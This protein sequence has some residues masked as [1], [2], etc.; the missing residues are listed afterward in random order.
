MGKR[1]DYPPYGEAQEII[2]RAGIKLRKEYALKYKELGLPSDPRVYYSKKGWT[3]W[4]TFLDRSE[5][6]PSYNEARE[7]VLKEGVLSRRKYD[8]VYKDLGLPSAPYRTYKNRGW[9]DWDSFLGKEEVLPYDVAKRIVQERGIKGKEEY[10]SVY[11]ELG[12][13]SAP[14]RTYKDKGWIKWD[15]FLGKYPTFEEAKVILKGSNIKTKRG[16]ESSHKE[17]GLPSDPRTYYQEEGWTSWSDLWRDL[18]GYSADRR[19]YNLFKRMTISPDILKDAPL[20]FI[21]ILVSYLDKELVKPIETLLSTTSYEERLNWVKKQLKSLKEGYSSKTKSSGRITLVEL[22]PV[23]SPEDYEEDPDWDPID[24]SS[25]DGFEEASDELSAMVAIR[26][27][28]DAMKES[29]SEEE[30]E[31]INKSWE[32]YLHCAVNRELIAEYD[33]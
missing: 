13:P 16:Y 2:K 12:L 18:Y 33:G 30:K 4:D 24:D 31:R 29:L 6:F 27:E 10:K 19:K 32:N 26:E 28:Y 1:I 23:D 8:S 9:V 14:D 21:Y 5:Q 25:E 3:D 22:S 7:L 17:L 20:Q 11:K 15:Y